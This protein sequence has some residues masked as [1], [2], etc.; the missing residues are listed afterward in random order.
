MLQDLKDLVGVTTDS[1]VL[2][3][4]SKV[5]G[6]TNMKTAADV[7]RIREM[8]AARIGIGYDELMKIVTP[9]ED[10]YV[11]CDHS[12][13]LMMLLN[14]GVVPS[15]VREGYFARMLVRRALRSIRTLGID[16]RAGRHGQ[17]AD[18][19]LRTDIPG[20]VRQPRGH[21][22]PGAGGRR[23]DTT[24]RWDGGSSWSRV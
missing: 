24:K 14:D 11:I 13:A 8:T 22:E 15:N 23:S 16:V 3:E 7:R 19:L 6:A 21:H 18:R 2:T 5:A 20:T 10:I 9:L 17:Q 12:R 1:P 4:Y